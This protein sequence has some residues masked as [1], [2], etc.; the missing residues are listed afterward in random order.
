MYSRP[1][2]RSFRRNAVLGISGDA[3]TFG[4]SGV[5]GV[6]GPPGDADGDAGGVSRRASIGDVPG[7]KSDVPGVASRASSSSASIAG[8]VATIC[9]TSSEPLDA[10]VGEAFASVP[11]TPSASSRVEGAPVGFFSLN[12]RVSHDG[13]GSSA[14]PSPS[15]SKNSSSEDISESSP[16]C[17]SS[18]DIFVR[19]PRTLAGS[20]PPPRFACGSRLQTPPC[21][22][23]ARQ[24]FS[25][26]LT[27]WQPDRAAFPGKA[28][29]RP[30]R[31][32]RPVSVERTSRRDPRTSWETQRSRVCRARIAKG[33]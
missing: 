18:R 8:F 5:V 12:V 14:G 11:A 2:S 1:V 15:G 22:K 27:K 16:S 30:L 25:N 6:F 31:S 7:S 29:T 28:A 23:G 3:G 4:T 33:G 20:L 10:S 24:A 17:T 26:R 13:P 32:M 9:E 21:T 19:V